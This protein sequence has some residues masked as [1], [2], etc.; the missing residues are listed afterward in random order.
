M[1]FNITLTQINDLNAKAS[2]V[3]KTKTIES[4]QTAEILASYACAEHSAR[5]GVAWYVSN[6]SC[7][8]NKSFICNCV[9]S[10]YNWFELT[11]A[12]MEVK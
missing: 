7:P 1:T 12:V 5:T 10:Y 4:I 3:I 8:E 9:P 11:V 6:I 2:V